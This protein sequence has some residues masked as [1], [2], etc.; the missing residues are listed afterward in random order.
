MRRHVQLIKLACNT[1]IQMHRHVYCKINLATKTPPGIESLFEVLTL[2]H[3][4][5]RCREPELWG[6]SDLWLSDYLHANNASSTPW[7]TT[8]FQESW[9]LW[10]SQPWIVVLSTPSQ[11]Q[12]SSHLIR[13]KK[14]SHCTIKRSIQRME[15]F[16]AKKKRQGPA[17]EG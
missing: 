17:T 10:K 4:V 12:A 3:T 14:H 15:T 16:M 6:G 11:S 1:C 9:E 7:V 13:R 5:G 8:A 2:T